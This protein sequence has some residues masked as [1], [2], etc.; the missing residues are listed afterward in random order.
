MPNITDAKTLKIIAKT[1]NR[2]F[3]E[4]KEN[5]FFRENR[6]PYKVWISE[7]ALQQTRIQAALSPLKRFFLNFPDINSLADAS[8]DKVLNSFRGLG[9]YNRARN[10]RKGAIYIKEKLKGRFPETSKELKQVPSIGD[11]TAAAISSICFNENIAVLDG[12]VKR[13]LSRLLFIEDFIETRI[14]LEKCAKFQAGLFYLAAVHPGDLN[15]AFMELGQKICL[16]KNMKCEICPLFSFCKAAQKNKARELPL[17]GKKKNLKDVNWHIFIIVD[18]ENKVLLQK[19]ESFYFLKNQWAFPS[20]L[21]FLPEQNVLNSC[22]NIACGVM[23]KN[24]LIE[25]NIIKHSITNHKIKIYPFVTKNETVLCH[26]NSMRVHSS[27]IENYL[28]SSAM[29]KT[30]KIAQK[31]L[32][33]SEKH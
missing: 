3:I 32:T 2:W 29:L 25:N 27:E 15:E 24:I 20:S 26:E 6:T 9:Y 31:H 16:P 23:Q 19:Y 13:I 4:N 22:R 5:W 21:F 18:K 10:L 7:V 11:Y 33:P 14:F 8:E 12:N 30:W 28:A 17:K 1:L